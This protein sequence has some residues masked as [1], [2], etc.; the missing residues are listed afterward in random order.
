MHI[1]ILVAGGGIVGLLTLREIHKIF[2]D[3][4]KALLEKGHYFGDA[5]SGRNSGVMHAG[6]YYPSDS[7]KLKFCLEGNSLWEELA[8]ELNIPFS[9]CGKYLVA[10]TVDEVEVLDE[11]FDHAKTNG[12]QGLRWVKGDELSTLENYCFVEEAFFSPQSGFISPSAATAAIRDVLFKKNIP[13]MNDYEVTG[14][15]KVGNVFEIRT[16]RE[17]FTC[18]IFINATG[19]FA[20]SLRRQLG[21]DD[22]EAYWVKGNY[23]KLNKKFYTDSLIYPVPPKGLKGLGVHTSFDFDGGVVRFG[24]D[25]QECPKGY[26]HSLNENLVEEMYP[27]ISKLFKG[28][29][30]ED[31]QQDYCG[32]RAKIKRHGELF[33]DFWLGTSLEHGVEGYF[34]FLGIESPGLTAAPALAKEMAKQV[35]HNFSKK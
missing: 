12:V 8:H 34:E 26:E 16:N 30:R 15:S 18:D 7:L 25:T 4:D 11:L 3:A 9:R 2:P 22:F 29:E 21:L 19:A 31:L 17:T 33:S 27:A 23:L 20:P 13:L 35:G 14:V 10:A 6:L 24:P 28:I 5:A 1:P 32:I